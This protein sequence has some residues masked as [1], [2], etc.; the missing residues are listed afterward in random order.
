MARQVPVPGDAHAGEGDG[1][2]RHREQLLCQQA[3]G[4]GGAVEAFAYNP[5]INWCLA[6]APNPTVADTPHVKFNEKFVD[7][8]KRVSCKL[9]G[10]DFEDGNEYAVKEHV[11]AEAH[12]AEK[13]WI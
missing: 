11:C 2:Q 10:P 5:L 1:E 3:V 7:V 4:A 13:W 9:K 6:V 8:L 12:P